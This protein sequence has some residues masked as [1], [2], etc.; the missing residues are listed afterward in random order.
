MDKEIKIVISNAVAVHFEN[1]KSLDE[2]SIDKKYMLKTIL[3]SLW[4]DITGKSFPE[5]NI[6]C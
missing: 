3:E 2:L 5:E 1:M 6:I 4:E